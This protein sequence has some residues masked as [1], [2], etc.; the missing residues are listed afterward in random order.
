MKTEEGLK[1]PKRRNRW[2][3]AVVLIVF[4]SLYQQSSAQERINQK[5]K[6][7]FSGKVELQDTT[8]AVKT[9]V[10]TPA[11]PVMPSSLDLSKT[12]VVRVFKDASGKVTA[13]KL[14][15]SSYDIALDEGGK[16]IESMD[17][18]KVSVNGILCMQD[19]KS[20]FTVKKVGFMTVD[21]TK[22]PVAPVAASAAE[23]GTIK[24]IDFVG[25][26]HEIIN[27]KKIKNTEMMKV[28]QDTNSAV[29]KIVL[30][31]GG[32]V[33]MAEVSYKS[34]VSDS[35][36]IMPA[37]QFNSYMQKSASAPEIREVG[38]EIFLVGISEKLAEGDEWKGNIYECGVFEIYPER[39][40][41]RM[42]ATTKELAIEI[43]HEQ[44]SSHNE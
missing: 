31:K 27:V 21:H 25:E 16:V 28:N 11:K 18:Q 3:L 42:Y 17:G 29:Y 15:V 23:T 13:I 22:A 9:R 20:Y 14:I 40:P 32:G 10:V 1:R 2:M 6:S 33:V 7:P 26:P 39:L 8:P 43:Q 38:R 37:R 12:G 34:T 4:A 44:I 24:E 41:M 36:K 5:A 35:G 19:N 30:K